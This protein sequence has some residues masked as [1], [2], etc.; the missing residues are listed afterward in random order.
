MA[1][2]SIRAVIYGS[3]GDEVFA[4]YASKYYAPHLISSL[5][6]GKF[7]TFIKDFYSCSEFAEKWRLQDYALMMATLIP[8]VPRRATLG[9][10]G[11]VE[12]SINPISET[13]R[14]R[15]VFSPPSEINAL[16]K[17]MIG[18]WQMNYWLR[19]DNTSSMSIPIELR[20]PFIDHRIIEY[21]FTLPTT[22]LIMDGWLKWIV[23]R[24]ME[25]R[26]P[27]EI[28]WRRKKM[29]FPF[30][31]YQWMKENQDF[32]RDLLLKV[33]CPY[34]DISN[35]FK[36]FDRINADDTSYLWSLVSILL[37]WK[38]R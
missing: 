1:N 26:L 36:F 32:F 3:A 23:R 14:Y 31:L 17:A 13:I 20:L 7:L 5:R 11:F 25:A 21:G 10:I 28:V 9:R 4:G 22:Y 37:W 27:S 24:S 33:D 12:R 2:K 38:Y 6:Q 18:D 15:K 35:L 30:P 29:G 8:V 34:V 19:I 16:L